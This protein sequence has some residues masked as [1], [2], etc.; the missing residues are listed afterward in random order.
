MSVLLRAST[1]SVVESWTKDGDNEVGEARCIFIEL[2]PADHTMIREIFC[3]ARFR[4]PQVLR[5]ARLDGFAIAA[6]R[7]AS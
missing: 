4:D 3:D 5:Q 6:T 2:E 7:S 1:I